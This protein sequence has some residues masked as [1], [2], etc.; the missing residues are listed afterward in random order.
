[1]FLSLLIKKG[2]FFCVR[3][4][5]EMIMGVLSCREEV[6]IR[7][8]CVKHW[9]NNHVLRE[10]KHGKNRECLQVLVTFTP[11]CV[12]YGSYSPPSLRFLSISGVI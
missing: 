10:T 5:D 8:V 3:E 2:Y 9:T 12:T 6:L 11:T 4:K 7:S 1:M